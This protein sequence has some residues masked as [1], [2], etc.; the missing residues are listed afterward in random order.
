MPEILRVD[1][2]ALLPDLSGPRDACVHRLIGSLRGR[3]GFEYIFVAE[4][5]LSQSTFSQSTLS[6]SAQLCIHYDPQVLTPARIQEIVQKLGSSLHRYICHGTST[7]AAKRLK[8]EAARL[9]TT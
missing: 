5:V 9:P 3:E 4:P 6:P 8:A 7:L 1:L 2:S